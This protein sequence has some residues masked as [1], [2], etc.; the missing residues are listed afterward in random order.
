MGAAPIRCR[1]SLMLSRCEQVAALFAVV[2]LARQS[3]QSPFCRR[4]GLDGSIVKNVTDADTALGKSP[5]HQQ[6]TMTVQRLA[7]RAQ[8]ADDP[9]AWPSFRSSRHR[10]DRAGRRAA[11]RQAFHPSPRT[12]RRPPTAPPQ[13]AF[14]RTTG[15]S[16]SRGRCARQRSGPC[17][18]VAAASEIA[19]MARSNGQ[20]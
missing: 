8:D 9:G 10:F 13:A 11:V 14:A 18:R 2:A 3:E 1:E 15:R 6:A 4:V 7:L 16:G 17:R 19:P 20:W 12:Q 5:R